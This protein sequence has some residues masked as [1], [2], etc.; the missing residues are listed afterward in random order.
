MGEF[1]KRFWG[2][3]ISLAALLGGYLAAVAVHET[4]VFWTACAG[5]GVIALGSVL[6]PRGVAIATKVRNYPALLKRTGLLADEAENLKNQLTELQKLV[7]DRW[8]A[9]RTEGCRQVMGAVLAAVADTPPVEGIA[10]RDG[11][12]LL[13]ARIEGNAP[14]IGSRFY[15]ESSL[16]G[17][18]MGVVEVS[19][20]DKARQKLTLACIEE[21]NALFWA[22]LTEAATLNATP[23]QGFVLRRYNMP[24]LAAPASLSGPVA[25]PVSEGL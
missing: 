3:A 5:A 24:I 14:A 8:E 12:P 17:E 10:L 1:L 20:R 2:T 13:I 15:I 18:V 6:I 7:D 23:P 22:R 4:W 19:V 25:A 9:G 21:T 11:R 16:T